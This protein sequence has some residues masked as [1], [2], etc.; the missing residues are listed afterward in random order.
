[1]K[2]RILGLEYNHRIGLNRIEGKFRWFEFRHHDS[3]F[4]QPTGEVA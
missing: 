3:L 1:M 2:N 4:Q